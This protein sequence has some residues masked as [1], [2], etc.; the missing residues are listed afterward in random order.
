MGLELFTMALT[1]EV[2]GWA[3]PSH[4][5]IPLALLWQCPPYILLQPYSGNAHLTYYLGSNRLDLAMPNPFLLS[6]TIAW[7]IAGAILCLMELFIPTALVQFTMGLSAF[8][9]AGISL[10]FPQVSLQVALWL[11]LSV[12]GL[13]VTRRLL[14][15]RRVSTIEAAREGETITEIAPGQPGRVL[16]EGNSW[17]ARCDDPHTAIGPQQKVIIVG[18]EGNTLIVV[19]ENILHSSSF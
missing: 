13:V 7:L 6:P 19:P 8:A 18:R 1:V 10:V 17:R 11:G 12:G 9:V 14:P 5:K 16:Y 15:K 4:W 2:V 3:L